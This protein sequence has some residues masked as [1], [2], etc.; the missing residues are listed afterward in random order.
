MFL[1]LL[2]TFF[3]AIG[4]NQAQ[5]EGWP[6][7]IEIP[8]VGGEGGLKPG[9]TVKIGDYVNALYKFAMTI[10]GA[11]ALIM[12]MIGGFQYMAAASS[13]N[14]ASAGSAKDT[15]MAALIGML[16]VAFAYVILKTINP[17]LTE[18]RNP[19]N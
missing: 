7:E 19:F 1:G 11:S 14:N 4:S 17:D 5:A 9:K 13:G 18:L 6:I 15:M 2:G 16:I 10:T 3:L 12:F 8:F